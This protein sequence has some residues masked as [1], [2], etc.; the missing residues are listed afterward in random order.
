MTGRLEVIAREV[1]HGPVRLVKLI[2]DAVMFASADTDAL[3]EAA[4]ELLERMAEGEDE[5]ELP[6]IRAGCAYGPV[7]TRGGDYYGRSVNSRAGSPRPRPRERPRHRGDPRSL[8]ERRLQLLARPAQTPC[9]AS[10]GASKPTR[11]RRTG[12]ETDEG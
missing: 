11:C 5:D 9:R 10:R 6:L 2:G 12:Q 7:F 3:L 4:H 8:G 1:S